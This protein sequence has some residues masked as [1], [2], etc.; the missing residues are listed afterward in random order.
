MP[1]PRRGR[2][3][4]GVG[5]RVGV[6]AVGALEGGETESVDRDVRVEMLKD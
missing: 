1:A 5:F 6:E 4:L 3:G 2:S